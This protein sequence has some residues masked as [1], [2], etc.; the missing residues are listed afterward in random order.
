[1]KAFLYVSLS[2]L[3]IFE[4]V[5]SQ[6][7]DWLKVSETELL[8]LRG[9]HLNQKSDIFFLIDTSGSLSGSDFNEEKKFVTNLLNEIR[10]SN[11]GTRVEVIPFGT[12]AS[13]YIDQISSASLMKNKCTFNAK[14]NQL[15]KNIN[16]FLTN[17]KD[18]FNLVKQVSFGTLNKDKRVPLK[19]FKTTAILITDG[20]WNTPSNDPSPVSLAQEIRAAGVEVFAIGVGYI[21]YG[22]LRQ[23]V[24]NP[25]KQAFHLQDFT[26]FSELATY[27]RGDPYEQLWETQDVDPSNCQ[28]NCDVKATC[29]CGL[30]NGDYKC[31]CPLGYYGSGVV[32]QCILCPPST[33]KDFSGHA[34]SCTA[35]PLNSGHKHI[36]SRSRLDCECDT[37]YQGTPENGNDCTIRK[38][39]TLP[40]PTDGRIK[41][42]SCDRSYLSYCTFECDEGYRL[43]GSETRQCIVTSTNVIKWSGST[44]Q[45]E[46]I[47][48]PYTVVANAKNAAGDCTSDGLEYR[49]NCSFVCARGYERSG[50]ETVTC[51]LDGQWSPAHPECI[52]ITCPALPTVSVG[53]YLPAMCD[54]Q[55]SFVDQGC[56]LHCPDGYHISYASTVISSD[57]RR[58]LINGTWEYR[59]VSPTCKD[60]R[61]PLLTCPS[62]TIQ[63]DNDPGTNVATVTWDFSFNDN[64]LVENEP[65]ITND[66]FTITLK[67]NGE[68]MDTDLPKLLGIGSNQ[69]EYNVTDNAG[70]S[71]QCLFLVMVADTEPPS[72]SNCPADIVLDNLTVIEYIVPW[73]RPNCS[74]NSGVPPDFSSSRPNGDLFEVPSN[75]E[76]V[77]TVRD[78]AG[79]EDKSCS[80]AIR[81][82]KLTC[83]IYEPPENGALIINYFGSDPLCQVQCKRGYDFVTIPPQLYICA[84]GVWQFTDFFGTADTSLPWPDCALTNTPHQLKMGQLPAYFY[85]DG[86]CNDPNT[87]ANIKTSFITI[88]GF[89]KL[90]LDSTSC[91]HDTVQVFCGNVTQVA[92]RRRRST[93]REVSI[94]YTYIFPENNITEGLSGQAARDAFYQAK[95]KAN[96]TRTE[97]Y[98]NLN[99]VNWH[100]FQAS[101]GLELVDY[102]VDN[103]NLAPVDAYC[104]NSGAVVRKCDE[105]DL[106]CSGQGSC[107]C[108]KK[109]GN[110]TRCTQCPVGT[111]YDSDTDDCLLCPEGTYNQRGGVLQCTPCPEGTWTLGTRQE[112]FTACADECGPGY[113]S[114]TGIAKCSMCPTGTY[115]SGERNKACENCPSGTVTVANAAKGI[116]DCGMKCAPGTYSANG[117]EPCSPCPVGTYQTSLGQISCLPCPGVKS[118]HG[119][120]AS[121]D[122]FCTA[123][124]TCVSNPCINGGTCVNTK[125]SYRCDCPPGFIGVNCQI[126]INECLSLPC[127]RQSTCVDKVNSYQCLCPD[128]F[129]GNDCELPF[130]LC[131]RRNPCHLGVCIDKAGTFGCQC[132][133][134]YNGTFCDADINECMSSPCQNNGVCINGLATYTCLCQ[135][136]YSGINCQINIDDCATGPCQNGGTCVDGIRSYTCQCPVGYTGANCEH[137]IDQCVSQPCKN[138]GNCVNTQ[139]GYHCLCKPTYYGSHCGQV[140]SSNYDLSFQLRVVKSYS[141]VKKVIPD[142]TAFT[143]AFWMRT[144][145][146]KS[147]TVISYATRVGNIVQDN[148][149]SLQDYASF[150]LSVNNQTVFTG[151]KA[152]DGQWHHVA[153]TWE[154]AQGSW[155]AYLD[156]LNVRSSTTSFQRGEVITGNGYLILGQEQDTLGGGFNTEENFIGDISQM[157][158][159]DYVL[160]ANDVY[161]LV[162][163]CDYVKGNVAAWADFRERLFGEYHVTDKAYVCEFSS[164]LRQYTVKYKSYISGSHNLVLSN[165]NPE[166]CASSCSSQSSFICRSFDF[167]NSSNTCRMSSQSS[168]DKAL[169]TS[170]GYR[171]YELNCLKSLEVSADSVVPD[172]SITASSQRDAT[173][174]PSGGR[175][176]N[177]AQYNDQNVLTLIGAWA[178]ATADKNQWLQIMFKQTFQITGVA[179]QG[180]EDANYWV[181]TYKLDYSTDGSTWS[182]YGDIL[183]GNTDRSTVVRNEVKVF[184]AMYLRF[185]P[186]TWNADRIAMRVEAYGCP[187]TISK[188]TDNTNECLSASCLNGGTCVNRYNDYLCMCANGYTGRKCETASPCAAIGVPIYGTMSSRDYSAGSTL[189]FTC[190]AGYSLSGSN[191]RTCQRGA[192]TGSHPQC[193]D[194]NECNNNPC[195]Q[196]CKNTNGGYVCHCHKG[197]RLQGST[198]CVDIDEC[199]NSNGGCSHTCHNSIGSFSCTCPNGMDLESE[200]SCKDRDECAYSN[201]GCEHS[202]VNTYQSFYCLC[203][204]G[205]F[206]KADKKNCDPLSCPALSSP[207]NGN[208]ALSSG[209]VMGSTASY[210]CQSGYKATYTT[211]RYCQADGQWS[212]GEPS[213][214][215]VFCEEI[216]QVE[217][218]KRV[219]TGAD[220]G[221]SV[222]GTKAT[223]TCDANYEMTAD[224]D[225]T[226]TCQQNGKW[227]GTQPRC[228]A[229]FCSPVPVPANGAVQGFRYELGATLRVTC[230]QGYNLVPSSSS[231]RTCVSN[232]A[233]GGQWTEVD[234]TCE[235]VDCKDPGNPYGGFRDISKGTTF[236]SIVTYTCKP[237]HHLEGEGSQTCQGNGQWSGSKPVCLERSCGNPGVPTNGNKN[238]SSYQ[239]GN[240]IKFK[241]NVGYTLQGS[242][243]RTC[244]NNG[245]WTGTQPTCHIVSCGDP[246]IP[247]NGVRY[248][249]IFTYQSSV[250][251]ECDPGYKLVGDLTRT[252]QADGSWTG[253]QPTCQITNCGTF[254]N[255]PN[256]VVTSPSYPAHYSDNEYCTWQIQVPVNKKIRLDFSEF[257]TQSGHDFVLI[258]DTNHFQTPSIAFDGT[259]YTPPPFTSSG[260]VVRVRFV[261]DGDTNFKGFSFSYKQVDQSCG[262][263]FEDGSGSFSSPGFPNGYPDNTDCV[264]LLYRNNEA[265]EF[266]LTDYATESGHDYLVIKSG[267]F[268]ERT[269]SN[270]WSGHLIP[271]FSFTSESYL[272]LR[273]V[274]NSGNSDGRQHKGWSGKYQ[275]YWPYVTG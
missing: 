91:S 117:V 264:W 211:S 56:T 6:N 192:W 64:S 28:N 195:N 152:N 42:G 182:S 86:D 116:H 222:L 154:S 174:P 27:L 105:R 217:H 49:T 212:G 136:G 228:V 196:W 143:I 30:V 213:C 252:C 208:M 84:T 150:V 254:L 89:A 176:H 253:S 230:N 158:V 36:G 97:I 99:N 140:L 21:D 173:T 24:E 149:L 135:A 189:T 157:N 197:Y 35:C 80:F 166:A 161:N 70:N 101:S 38:C 5:L 2:L 34:D 13:I 108:N 47:R 188:P 249:D 165:S 266:I 145:D 31:A 111:Y 179:T 243:I 85:F 119:T 257:K 60:F 29:A 170:A 110:V 63:Q 132:P 94:K 215:R 123:V 204:Q 3:T 10:V 115:S 40:I 53:S 102:N 100:D 207:A 183:T 59:A 67:I 103:F 9:E 106:S 23:V 236:Q 71:A 273:F 155:I 137:P 126:E 4:V 92:R 44:T 43:T 12:T 107:P 164:S 210:T 120:G 37:G 55:P 206:L 225:A 224:G 7:V 238:S 61:R 129:T 237:N 248:R 194:D 199:S 112:N 52:R 259:T 265:T 221:R 156:G 171:Y 269:F 241:C 22:R 148:A 218:A 202:C 48:C 177:Q 181:T 263:V 65:G 95:V 234:P 50:S 250:L 200:R 25:D 54:D 114:P 233:S 172:S 184:N 124:D 235:L 231:F 133:T 270:G 127:Y 79:N 17:M 159:F 130:S 20:K 256:G 32:G 261:S 185:K 88:A 62:A 138:G 151:L 14:F 15:N 57:L 168:L 122:S 104:S 272:W 139:T 41:G 175:L 75:S 260:N 169:S 69:V 83:P 134:G 267:R 131:T 109:E 46:V 180:Q 160:S 72:C 51:Q 219:L 203:R 246:G 81:L 242:D 193:S 98:N 113:F 258:Y 220:S 146:T 216:G 271:S 251:L 190:N 1:M 141:R 82:S 93:V 45:C 19:S 162:Y 163:S 121:S 118:T 76:V 144:D 16:G 223:F 198:T 125:E 239:Y 268:G 87:Q 68:Y 142:L 128:E 274:T 178:A 18:A 77:Y 244:Q 191:T 78:R 96:E 26:Q 187:L 201:G 229:A 167:D 205:Y 232:G 90:C 39:E 74:D 73:T 11:G 226:R 153:V 245:L 147:G 247:A 66:S 255:G 214:I 186:Q 227:S 262:G 8:K 209:L 33:Y 275:R 58:C 240:S